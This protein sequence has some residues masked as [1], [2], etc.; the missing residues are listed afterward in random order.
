[1]A[2]LNRNFPKKT[3]QPQN[4][5]SLNTSEDLYRNAATLA[6]N[7]VSGSVHSFPNKVILPYFLVQQSIQLDVA[8]KKN[9][10]TPAPRTKHRRFDGLRRSCRTCSPSNRSCAARNSSWRSTTSVSSV[11][12]CCSTSRARGP[13]RA[14]RTV[15][16]R[17]SRSTSSSRSRRRPATP[18]ST[19]IT[20]S[21]G[22]TAT[23][24][25]WRFLADGNLT[26][27]GSALPDFNDRSLMIR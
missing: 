16:T 7:S 19:A 1:M 9:K 18:S 20:R 12:R 22:I 4:P 14:R 5:Y 13:N 6:T 26:L 23:I 15:S 17:S 21:A 25:S 3:E 11:T 27:A 10:P 24:L 2:E 8:K